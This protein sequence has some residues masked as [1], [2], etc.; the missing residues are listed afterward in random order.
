MKQKCKH[1]S[2]FYQEIIH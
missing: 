1:I 2:P